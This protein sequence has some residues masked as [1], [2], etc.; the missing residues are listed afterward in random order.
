MDFRMTIEW[1]AD[2]FWR[3]INTAIKMAL[4]NPIGIV[5]ENW[6][7]TLKSKVKATEQVIFDI[8][9]RF[10][11]YRNNKPLKLVLDPCIIFRQPS[12]E[13]KCCSIFNLFWSL[14]KISVFSETRCKANLK[15][16]E[17]IK[18]ASYMS[19]VKLIVINVFGKKI[20]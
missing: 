5:A 16:R 2:S 8:L 20:E 6:K 13:Q 11:I 1:V 7:L 14:S 17:S 3:T 12:S 9:F 18:I 19:C 15:P 4:L 10:L